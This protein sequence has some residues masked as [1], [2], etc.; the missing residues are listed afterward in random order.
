MLR[1][2]F[3]ADDFDGT[4]LNPRGLSSMQQA[5]CGMG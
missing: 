4:F 5:T 3:G 2:I 1:E